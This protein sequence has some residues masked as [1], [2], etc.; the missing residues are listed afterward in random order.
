M[1]T[2]H[3]WKEERMRIWNI[4]QDLLKRAQADSR[5]LTEDENRQFESAESDFNAATRQ[6]EALQK[7]EERA[8]QF[9]TQQAAAGA[10]E[11]VASAPVQDQRTAGEV[12]DKLLRAMSLGQGAMI[13]AANEYRSFMATEKRGTSTQVVG[14]PSLGGYLVPQYWWDNII[15]T[16]KSY[17]PMLDPAVVNLIRTADGA[18]W[19]IPTSDQ[20]AVKGALITETTA[21][22]VSDITFGT[23][24]LEAYLYTS[25]L[26]LASYEMLQDS[27]YDLQGFIA[28][29]I[30][31]R[32]GRI[33]NEALTTGD[34]S[35]K[36]NG[37]VTASAAGKTASATNAIT[38]SEILDLIHSVDIA[39]RPNSRLM[40]NDATIL[41]I[42]KLTVGSS[43]DRPLWQPSIRDGEPGTIEGY[44]YLI[45]NDMAT[46]ASGVNSR[47][48]LFGD[49]SKYAVRVVNNLEIKVLQ[50]LY[51]ASRS[52]GYFG[53]LRLDGELLDSAA[54]KHLKLAA[55]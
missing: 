12:F 48:M 36:P 31:E 27:A 45:N 46:L 9:A 54:V 37:V 33:A 22:V 50:E 1:K 35:S 53:F 8:K 55:S 17:G 41:A 5:A 20:T 43:D 29:A 34:G 42:K 49:F 38:R 40:M 19:N 28:R 15:E 23:K 30:A 11:N 24:A 47:V 18:K 4:Q 44:S 3:D 16:M 39:Y 25:R 6:I 14:T 21:D 10:T 2:I 26:I 13:D 52:V 32:V 51:A 7:N